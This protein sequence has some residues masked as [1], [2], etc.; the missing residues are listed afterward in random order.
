MD[1]FE[2]I[3]DLTPGMQFQIN[4]PE[5][6]QVIT[7]AEIDGENVTIDGNHP[8]AGET[9]HFHIEVAEVREATQEELDHGHIHG[10]GC[11]HD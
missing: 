4:R 1:M 6:T 3:E 2:G 7:V 10:P 8:L 9:L 11:H 5:G